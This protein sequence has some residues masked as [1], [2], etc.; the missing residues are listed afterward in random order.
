M[1][2]VNVAKRCDSDLGRYRANEQDGADDDTLGQ[3]R[4][5]YSDQLP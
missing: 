2:K 5:G 1:V 3:P 4:A